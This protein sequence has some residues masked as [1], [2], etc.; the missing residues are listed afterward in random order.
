MNEG[1]QIFVALV[2][3]TISEK[4]SQ[5]GAV[6]IEELLKVKVA[7]SDATLQDVLGDIISSIR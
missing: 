2:S 7:D 5:E 4:C 1:F 6:S 3:K